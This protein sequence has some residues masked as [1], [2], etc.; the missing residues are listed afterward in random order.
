MHI[1][2]SGNS[3]MNIWRNPQHQFA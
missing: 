3:G 1:G 2:C